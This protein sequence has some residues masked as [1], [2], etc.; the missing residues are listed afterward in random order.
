MAAWRGLWRASL[1]A[2]GVGTVWYM[3]SV[4]SNGGTLNPN[5]DVSALF[6]RAAFWPLG[7]AVAVGSAGLLHAA[8]AQPR[9]AQRPVAAPQLLA[10]PDEDEEDEGEEVTAD[11]LLVA[12]YLA[13]ALSPADRAAF[14]QRRR[15]DPELE[16]WVGP[17]LQLAEA[18]KKEGRE[19]GEGA[20]ARTRTRLLGE[21]DLPRGQRS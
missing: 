19:G 6:F 10:E 1:A 21:N 5:H 15:E 12:D 4:W 16:A 17:V 20:L 2:V 8:L 7:V 13:R 3:M 11:T 14:E 9:L 18:L